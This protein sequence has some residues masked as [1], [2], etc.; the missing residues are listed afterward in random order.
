MKD[1]ETN[2]TRDFLKS[3]LHYNEE[4][5]IFTWL[6]SYSKAKKGDVAGAEND[7]GYVLI[8]I[9]GFKY[10]AHRLAWFY[11]WGVWPSDQLDHKNT[12]RTDNSWKN[13]REASNQLNQINT[14]VSKNNSLGF[15][16]VYPHINRRTKTLRYRAKLNIAGKQ[17]HLGTFDSPELASEAYQRAAKEAFGEYAR[18]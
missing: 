7:S 11:V 3:I 10:R 6:K 1:F 15:K 17:I 5:G 14:N 13:L 16:G 8:G 2:L 4:T 12:K 18:A 9:N